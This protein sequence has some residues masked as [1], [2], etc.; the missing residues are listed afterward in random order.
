M[1]G[2]TIKELTLMAYYCYQE[3]ISEKISRN[4][5]NEFKKTWDIF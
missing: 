5:T 1:K 4:Y 3:K 2:K